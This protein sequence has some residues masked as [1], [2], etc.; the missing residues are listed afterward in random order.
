MEG[1]VVGYDEKAEILAQYFS[2]VQWKVRFV[3]VMLQTDVLGTILLIYVG[4][5]TVVELKKAGRSLKTGK[6]YD[7]DEILAEFWKVFLEDEEYEVF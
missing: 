4:A 2:R 3:G 1:R 7:T 5:I 6:V